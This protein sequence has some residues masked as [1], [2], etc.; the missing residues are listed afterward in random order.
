M[1]EKKIAFLG[2]KSAGITSFIVSIRQKYDVENELR[3]I[4]P[5]KSIQS[6]EFQF[7][8][9]H[10]LNLDY[11]GD[12]AERTQY[13]N[14]K[15]QSFANI[16]L[17]F[18][19]VDIQNAEAFDEAL[20]YFGDILLYLKQLK[21]TVPVI[22][23]F[24]KM[25]P[26]I[27]KDPTIITNLNQFKDKLQPFLDFTKFQFFTSTVFETHTLIRAYSAGLRLLFD[28]SK[29]VQNFILD[30]TQS[31]ENII[32]CLVFDA[33]GFV[34]GE[35]LLEQMTIAQRKVFGK[36]FTVIQK[37]IDAQE[38][39]DY[40]YM[41]RID[42]WTDITINMLSFEIDGTFFYLGLLFQG[43]EDKDKSDTLLAKFRKTI[44]GLKDIL[45]K[46]MNP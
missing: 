6:T 43:H 28:P 42:E 38:R 17:F 20:T 37:R 25:D 21:R 31:V 5:S 36:V 23:I 1:I 46:Q 39:D 2:L 32:A 41:E 30:C 29:M 8:N 40:E 4:K 24:H 34:V 19:I 26:N 27:I 45:I 44:P 7:M 13:L 22:V 12:I 11:S 3:K 9:H 14:N 15:S 33:Q 35:Y 16:D 18:F 10:F